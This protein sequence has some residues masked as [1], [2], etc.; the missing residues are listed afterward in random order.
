MPPVMLGYA[1]TDMYC[2]TE[3]TDVDLV[4][5]NPLRNFSITASYCRRYLV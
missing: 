2:F 1:N 4:T 5:S 3:I